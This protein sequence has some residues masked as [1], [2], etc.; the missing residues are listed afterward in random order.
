MDSPFIK[1]LLREFNRIFER[2]TLYLITIIFPIIFF[3]IYGFIYKQELIREVPISIYDEDNSSLSQKIKEQIEASSSLKIAKYSFNIYE[4]KNDFRNGE[5]Y[6][7]FHIPKGFEKNIKKGKNSTVVVYINSTNLILNNIILKDATT[8]IKT[9]SASILLKKIRSKGN[10]FN[11]SLDIIN[12]VRIETASLYNYNYSYSYYLVPGLI[13]FTLQMIIMISSVLVFSSEFSHN[14]FEELAAVGKYNPFTIIVGKLVSHVIIHLANILLILFILFPLFN[15][16]V[17]GSYT[18]LFFVYIIFVLANLSIAF[19]VSSLIKDQQF[20]SELVVFFNT[21]AFIFSGFT[22]PLWAM[23]KIHAVI[24]YTMPFTY[25][26]NASIKVM[27]MN[28]NISFIKNEMFV[29]VF[30]IIFFFIITLISIARK[31]KR[32]KIFSKMD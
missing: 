19:A 18:L 16:H 4:I 14:S 21:P 7:A 15:I 26:M 29:F 25:F 9:A 10:S 32:I 6:G 23:P 17:N 31:T 30:I 8:I 13:G 28:C 3:L 27:Y 2:K 20:A 12:P 11:K 24:A 1:I 5:I 22:F